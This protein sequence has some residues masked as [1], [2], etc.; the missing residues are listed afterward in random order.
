MVVYLKHSGDLDVIRKCLGKN[1][2]WQ[3][4]LQ[5][6]QDQAILALERGVT[7]CSVTPNQGKVSSY[8]ASS[9]VGRSSRKYI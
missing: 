6:I 8:S 1:R 2:Q 7:R 5:E 9:D 4:F 3:W